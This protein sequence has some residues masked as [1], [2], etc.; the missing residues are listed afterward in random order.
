M[1]TT[2]TGP[3]GFPLDPGDALAAIHA[4]LNTY[5]LDAERADE[6]RQPLDMAAWKKMPKRRVLEHIEAILRRLA[7][8]YEHDRQLPAGHV[9]RAR[10]IRLLRTLHAMTL[11]ATEADLCLM[12][13][14]TTP[15]LEHIAPDGPVEHVMRYL[16]THDLTENLSQSLRRFDAEVRTDVSGVAALQSL[17]QRLHMLRWLDEWEPLDPARCWSECVRRDFRAMT[18]QQRV[19]WRGLLSHL[20]GNAPPKM[21]SGWAREAE[22]RLSAVGVDDFRR[23][24]ATW[25]LPFRSATPLPLS[26]AGSH[27]L[28]GLIWYAALTRDEEVRQIALWLL[29]V[30]WKQKRNVEKSML[31]LE[32]LGLSRDDLIARGVV[33]PLRPATDPLPRILAAL[34][35]V[36]SGYVAG[37]MAD[38]EDMILVQGELH[39]YR[40]FRSSGRIERATDDRRIELDWHALPDHLRAG[41]GPDADPEQ[42]LRHQA[43][44]LAHDSLYLPYFR[45][46]SS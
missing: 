37:R 19:A 34:L 27:V 38:T 10:L 14:L 43:F 1:E 33:A 13:D 26:V 7:W 45:P 46:V 23:H 42:Q 20:R 3:D 2:P 39:Y 40:L 8:L 31:A 30:K 22:P 25:F 36:E 9:A 29:D 4:S 21:P 12:L 28:K 18:G 15:L 35:Q 41:V 5:L 24:L 17:K 6:I 11:P 32:A 44:M 16:K